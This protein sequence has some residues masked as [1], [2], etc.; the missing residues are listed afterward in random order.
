M[1]KLF[2]VSG[3]YKTI[4][5]VNIKVQLFYFENLRSIIL[6]EFPFIK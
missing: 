2:I 6:K 4:D 5:F 3:S 1:I